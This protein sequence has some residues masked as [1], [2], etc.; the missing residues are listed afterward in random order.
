MKLIEAQQPQKR[1]R[2]NPRLCCS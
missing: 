1:T 2:T